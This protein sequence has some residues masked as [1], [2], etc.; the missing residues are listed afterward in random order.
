MEPG[1]IP[2]GF[3]LRQPSGA[4]PLIARRRSKSGRGLPQSKTLR[5]DRGGRLSARFWTAPVLWRF[6]THRMSSVQKRQRTAAVQ[7]ASHTPR[8]HELAT[9]F[10]PLSGAI[11]VSRHEGR[12]FVLHSLD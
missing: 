3:G 2:P 6:S 7:D 12:G 10:A 11:V 5:E 1:G 8:D 9:A 4:F